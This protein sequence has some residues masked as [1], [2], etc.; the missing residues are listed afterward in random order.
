MWRVWTLSIGQRSTIAKP[1]GVSSTPLRSPLETVQ[2]TLDPGRYATIRVVDRGGGID[3]R[4]AARIFEPFV[5]TKPPGRGVGAGLAIASRIIS[6]LHGGAR[7]LRRHE[8]TIIEVF[9]PLAT[10]E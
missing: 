2:G 8:G 9:L 4:V 3:E 1:K 5:T 7:V 6:R 10:S